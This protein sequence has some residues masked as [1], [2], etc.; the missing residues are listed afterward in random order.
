MKHTEWVSQVERICAMPPTEALPVFRRF[1]AKLRLDPSPRD[2]H[3]VQATWLFAVTAKKAGALREASRAFRR[4]GLRSPG[5]L[6][7][8]PR[9]CTRDARSAS[10]KQGT[11]SRHFWERWNRSGRRSPERRP[12]RNLPLGSS[13]TRRDMKGPNEEPHDNALPLHPW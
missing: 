9:G 1:V 6:E 3:T 7:S 4:I 5:D 13:N 12:L 2:W 8:L 11:L 10:A